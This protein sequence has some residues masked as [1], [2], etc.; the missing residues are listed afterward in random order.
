MKLTER[1]I[2]GCVNVIKHFEGIVKIEIDGKI[3]EFFLYY[4]SDDNGDELEIYED[5]D[6]ITDNDIKDFI[7]KNWEK[8]G[9]DDIDS[10][11]I[12][13]VEIK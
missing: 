12:G 11:N 6:E 5:E 7:W 9:I 8:I 2:I 10:E 4:T 1:K 13:W 3:R